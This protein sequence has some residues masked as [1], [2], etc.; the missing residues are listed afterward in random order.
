MSALRTAP[1]QVPEQE[2]QD[3]PV[4][5]AGTGAAGEQ[6]SQALPIAVGR[7]RHLTGQIGTYLTIAARAILRWSVAIV[8]SATAAALIYRRRRALDAYGADI[9]QARRWRSLG[10]SPEE[11]QDHQGLGPEFVSSW[12]AAGFTVEDMDELIRHKIFVDEALAWRRAGMSVDVAS[13]WGRY[14]LSP[15][16]VHVWGPSGFRANAAYACKSAGLTPEEATMAYERGEHPA[17]AAARKKQERYVTL[18]APLDG[19]VRTL[20]E[21]RLRTPS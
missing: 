18:D 15:D 2:R 9:R 5:L 8:V 16:D 6:Q 11:A 10:L 14:R 1:Q 4:L 20:H 3:G 19:L 12:L 21:M 13:E 17:L 7:S